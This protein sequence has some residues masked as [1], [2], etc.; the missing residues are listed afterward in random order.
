MELRQK[1]R[2]IAT[3]VF[4]LML[5]YSLALPV[6]GASNYF[7]GMTGKM[8]SLSGTPSGQW[9]IP[10]GSV[11]GQSPGVTEVT[12]N[13]TTSTGSSPFY[14][15]VRNPAGETYYQSVGIRTTQVTFPD[16]DGDHP[17]GNWTVWIQSQGLVTTTSAR[18]RVDYTY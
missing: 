2:I 18:M 9:S 1:R 16:F 4:C 10:S 6:M 17:A 14:L 8:N 3:L 15:Y 11:L 13:L 5:C 12:V 7:T